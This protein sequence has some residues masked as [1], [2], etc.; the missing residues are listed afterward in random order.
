[1]E[2]QP[3]LLLL[4]KTMMVTEGVG[5]MLNPNLNMWELAAPMMEEWAHDNFGIKGK[6]KDAAKQ[7]YELVRKFPSIL[8][9]VEQTLENFSN[10]DGIKLHPDSIT[11][12]NQLKQHNSQQW[13]W[14]GWATLV[15]AAVLAVLK[16]P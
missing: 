9:Q 7:G 13:L 11:S 12:F 5:R 1:M 3:Q 10:K 2:T 8:E 15:M 4:Q 16:L 6:V 14:L